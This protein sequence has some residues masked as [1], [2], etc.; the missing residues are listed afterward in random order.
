M[1]AYF[2]P[3]GKPLIL[4]GNLSMLNLP[5]VLTE[6]KISRVLIVTDE[7]IQNLKL[8]DPLKSKL[9]EFNIFYAVYDKT[10]QNPTI[11][12]IEEG[13]IVYKENNCEA[14]IAVG[15]GSPMDCGKGIGARIVRPNKPVRKMK[16]VLKVRKRIP[17]FIAV[18]TT[19]G[20]GSEVT[21][22]AVVTNPKTHEKYA[23]ND[24]S[25][26]PRVVVLDPSL[27][28]GLPKS[29][30]ATTGMDAL[31]HA[32]E[33]FIGK[34]NTKK[35]RKCAVEAT[36]LIFDNL[37]IVYDNPEDL[38]A[39]SNMQWAAFLAGKAFTRA[40]VGYVHAIAHTLSG[41]YGTPHGLANAVILP[42]VLREYGKSVYKP[43]SRLSIAVNLCKKENSKKQNAEI[44][45]N[46]IIG[47]NKHMNI[48]DTIKGI[49][50]DDENLMVKR[51]LKEANPLY[52]VPKTWT[53]K[54][55]K[56]IIH[57]VLNGSFKM[58]KNDTIAAVSTAMQT[59][60]VGIVRISGLD[61]FKIIDK[62]FKA[63]SKKDTGNFLPGKLY[64]GEF[65][66][67]GFIDKCMC[68]IFKEPNSYTG[69]N[70]AEIHCH[71]GVWV[72]KGVLSAVLKNGARLADSGEFTR[73][74]FVNGK[75]DLS[76]AEGI[77]EM[78][79][80]ESTG[81]LNAA[82]KLALGDLFK[83]T[84]QYQ[85]QLT[86]IISEVE[87]NLDYP[88]EDLAV[89]NILEL[90]NETKEIF[91][92]VKN[93]TDTYSAGRMGT[94][95]DTI[96]ESLEIDGIKFKIIDTAGIREN[97]DKIE[98][99]G[100]ER[101]I[102]AINSAD[103]VLYLIDPETYGSVENLKIK[104]K[105]KG[106]KIITVLN[107]TDLKVPKKIPCDI[108]ISARD[109][110]NIEKLKKL[111]IKTVNLGNISDRLIITTER[112]FNALT[113]AKEKLTGCVDGFEQKPYDIIAFELR[114]IW[115]VLGE[116]TGTCATEEIINNIF[117]K[118]CLG[119]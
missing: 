30:T 67:D 70:M 34:S 69:E 13:L 105:L 5:K 90:K 21:L 66:G 49:K 22:A 56:R 62:L 14:I 65:F 18:P 24:P 25:L 85:K 54:E 113:R 112:H 99:L 57:S 75:M 29:I 37:K 43:L 118:F 92:N 60:A 68:V 36:K 115:D 117:S 108:E 77:I 4:S 101:T 106:K 78:I 6:R 40:Y 42:Y 76:G 10:V 7:T 114:Q 52:P 59:A 111:I 19:A 88:E 12:N 53:A 3:W 73:R 46:E 50:E 96:E 71:G 63:A 45:I 1:F 55:I 51:A 79:E 93:L 97:A 116:I 38:K 104:E 94:T 17:L 9:K 102:S 100:I 39:R 81:E 109:N 74:A 8:I 47:L 72:V 84:L 86:D 2:L 41:F 82:S 91:N 28:A 95:R 110:I 48:P 61:A 89:K 107:K 11:D 15:G 20:T 35:T 33:A 80:A 64:L 103:L 58:I 31:T 26:I 44:F 16:G 87:V 32:V 23:I 119:K 98:K 83:L 27:T